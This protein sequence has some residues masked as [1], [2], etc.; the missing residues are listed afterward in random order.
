MTR[1]EDA[2]VNVMS[3]E[4][5]ATNAMLNTLDFQYAMVCLILNIVDAFDS[6]N[7]FA[8]HILL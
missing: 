6:L 1:T 2:I 5:N 8:I 7:Y 4:I 3:M